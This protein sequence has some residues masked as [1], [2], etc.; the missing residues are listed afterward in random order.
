M[1]QQHSLEDLV[2]GGILTEFCFSTRPRIDTATLES[3]CAKF[4][5]MAIFDI[6][7]SNS[8]YTLPTEASIT[9]FLLADREMIL[10]KSL[11]VSCF[12]I[13]PFLQK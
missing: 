8:P 3:Y 9:I 6:Y 7:F 12:L 5:K 10:E 13:L 4:Q 2:L 11:V 1:L